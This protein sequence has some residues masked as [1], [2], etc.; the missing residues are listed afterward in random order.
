MESTGAPN[1]IQVS[2]DTADLLTAAGKGHWLSQRE[3]RVF[4]KGKGEMQ[5]YWVEP[6]NKTDMNAS[7][8]GGST[9]SAYSNLS[10][11][12]TFGTANTYT[13]DVTPAKLNLIKV[14]ILLSEKVTRLIDWNTDILQGILREILARRQASQRDP[15]EAPAAPYCRDKN[16]SIID[17]VKEIITL[18]SFDAA[19]VDL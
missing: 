3:D 8:H 4:A 9:S 6:R 17:E 15:D 18:P 5:T 11:H 19:A 12:R 16:V 7:V 14:N 1:R 2:L 10:A 13:G